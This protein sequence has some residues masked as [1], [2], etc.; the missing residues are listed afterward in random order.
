MTKSTRLSEIKLGDV[1]VADDGF[2]CIQANARL[3][4]EVDPR[5]NLFVSCDQGRHFLDGQIDD[6]GETLV[7]L[8]KAPT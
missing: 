1:V 5:G 3:T 4:V 7:G 8:T 2:T 6:D